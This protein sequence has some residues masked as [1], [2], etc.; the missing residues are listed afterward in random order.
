M[1]RFKA[2]IVL[3]LCVSLLL[4]ACNRHED[5]RDIITDASAG[6][7]DNKGASGN[8]D[9]IEIRVPD[10][11]EEELK[12]EADEDRH[13]MSDNPTFRDCGILVGAYN[14]TLPFSYKRISDEWTFN[15]SDYGFDEDFR[16]GPGERTTDTIHLTKEDAGYDIVVGL[17]NPYDVKCTIEEAYVYSLTIDRRETGEFYPI[18][19]LPGGLTW[20]ST[21]KEIIEVEHPTEGFTVD[22]EKQEMYLNFIYDYENYYM[23]TV[24][25]TKGIMAVTVK[26]YAKTR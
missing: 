17:Y 23:L 8:A 18:I 11:T 2:V 21:F 16:L 1:K 13:I 6:E 9:E 5:I 14:F 25:E 26:S 15:L 22:H 3:L 19:K 20:C 10:I 12:E 24:S 4:A 7:S